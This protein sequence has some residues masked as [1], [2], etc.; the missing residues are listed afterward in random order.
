MSKLKQRLG[1]ALLATAV[2]AISIFGI[3]TSA[4]AA[5]SNIDP[6]AIGSITMHKYSQ[7]T[8]PGLPGDGS[9]QT[10]PAGAVPLEGVEFTINQVT[11][12]GG[13]PIELSDSASWDAVQSYLLDPDTFTPGGAT[14]GAPVVQTTDVAGVATFGSLPVGIYYITETAPGANQILVPMKPFLIAIPTPGATPG[15]WLY[16]VNAYPKNTLLGGSKEL[17]YNSAHAIGDDVIWTIT[18]DIPNFAVGTTLESFIIN[19]PL[20]VE[21]SYVSAT[22]T[23]SDNT[24]LVED[25]DYMIVND[26]ND[27]TMTLLAPGIALAADVDSV[28]LAITTTL[29]SIGNGTLRN[30]ATILVNGGEVEVFVEAFMGALSIF[31]FTGANLPLTGAEFQVFLTEADAIAE[32]NPIT[33]D[34][35]TTFISGV[36]GTVLVPGLVA[37]EAVGTTYWVKET[38][39]PAGYVGSNDPVSVLVT[40]GST[41]GATLLS[42]ENTQLP[43][44]FLAETGSTEAIILYVVGGLLLAGAGA[45]LLT[46]R[47]RKELVTA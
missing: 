39:A 3:T 46:T 22:V 2:G 41:A 4:T 14:L 6:G 11:A 29:E 40:V 9:V 26:N 18:G 31:K 13:V 10:V 44:G 33:V 7:P 25:T 37:D 19:D 32:T 17:D 24:V 28:K 16:D 30:D 43:F 20:P 12:I 35:V 45:F 42:V 1:A 27:I 8:I 23:L 38:K 5:P 36:D 15:D 21:V 34:G 47:R